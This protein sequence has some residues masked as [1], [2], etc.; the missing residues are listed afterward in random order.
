MGKPLVSSPREGEG[1][2]WAAGR[3]A[4]G[5][6]G[7]KSRKKKWSK[8]SSGQR[9]RDRKERERRRRARSLLVLISGLTAGLNQLI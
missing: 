8:T 2:R 3:A 7:M 1:F 6:T 9:N 5:K 4:G